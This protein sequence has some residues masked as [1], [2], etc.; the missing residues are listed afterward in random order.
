MMICENQ[1]RFRRIYASCGERGQSFAKKIEVSTDEA[2]MKKAV[3]QLDLPEPTVEA[4]ASHTLERAAASVRPICFGTAVF[5]G[6]LTPAHYFVLPSPAK[7]VM[8][9]IA[10]AGAL[11]MLLLALTFRPRGKHHS[12]AHWIAELAVLNGA[13]NSAAH[14]YFVTDPVQSTNFM[15]IMISFGLVVWRP[16]SFY[17]MS[18]GSMGVWLWIAMHAPSSPLWTHFGFGISATFVVAMINFHLRKK[19][20]RIVESL[21][22]ADER[23]R[24]MLMESMRSAY[25]GQMA[26]GMAHEINNPLAIITGR[27]YILRKSAEDGKTDLASI[28]TSAEVMSRAAERIGAIVRSLQAATGTRAEGTNQSVSLRA[29]IG[30]TLSVIEPRFESAQIRFER[31]NVLDRV[32]ALCQPQYVGEILLALLE[33]AYDAVLGTDDPWISLAVAEGFDAERPVVRLMVRNSG[34]VISPKARARLFLPFFTT[35]PVGKG[36]GLAL[37]SARGLAEGMGGSLTLQENTLHT[38]F[39]LTLAKAEKRSRAA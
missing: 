13:W 4:C 28:G 19:N 34:P 14:L 6:L 10:G 18:L 15:I 37:S 33:N 38:T 1:D 9:L 29:V 36:K 31:P 7:E 20:V 35:K 2:A 23:S 26:A 17:V 30:E 27:L 25:I 21:R 5:Y 22:A 16:V 3:S 8:P 24:L 32:E 39:C 11:L 12:N